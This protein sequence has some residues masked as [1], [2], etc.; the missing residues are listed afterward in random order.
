VQDLNLSPTQK[1]DLV[2]FLRTLTGSAVY[3]AEKWSDPF[4]ASNQLSLI[5]LPQDAVEII[6]HG[7]GTATIACQAAAGLRYHLQSSTD[8]KTWS[9]VTALTSDATGRC[10]YAVAVSGNTFY[11][12][13]YEPP[14]R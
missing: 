14:A 7:D 8:L 10:E 13:T 4:D 5:V 6:P 9:H 11:R 2:A 1:T 3:T 12:Y